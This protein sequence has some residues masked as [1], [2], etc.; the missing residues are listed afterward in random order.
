ME[1]KH[2]VQSHIVSAETDLKLKSLSSYCVFML[3]TEIMCTFIAWDRLF[4]S[5]S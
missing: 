3:V 4:L 1:I 5:Y 2:I